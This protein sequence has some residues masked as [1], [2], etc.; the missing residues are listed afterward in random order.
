[1]FSVLAPVSRLLAPRAKSHNFIPFVEPPLPN[2]PTTLAARVYAPAKPRDWH[3]LFIEAGKPKRRD[4]FE[5]AR[6]ARARRAACVPGQVF[7]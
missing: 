1:M 7:A 3:A 4:P 6:H 5:L 2:Y